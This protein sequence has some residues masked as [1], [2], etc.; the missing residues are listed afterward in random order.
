MSLSDKFYD[1][2]AKLRENQTRLAIPT[3]T[4]YEEMLQFLESDGAMKKTDDVKKIQMYRNWKQQLF[5][6]STVI[7]PLH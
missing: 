7:F 3:K 2:F 5:S 6:P 4:K 1:E